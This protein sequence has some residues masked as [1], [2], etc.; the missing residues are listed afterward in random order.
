[1][2]SYIQHVKFISSKPYAFWYILVDNEEKVGSVYLTDLNEIGISLIKTKNEKELE[3]EILKSLMKKHPLKKY[4][5]N[6]SSKN[7]KLEIFVKKFGFKMIQKTYK[8]EK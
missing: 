2:P 1:M 6:I 4:F 8:F 3:R 7:K 5:I